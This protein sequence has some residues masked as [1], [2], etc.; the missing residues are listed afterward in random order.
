MLRSGL[1]SFNLISLLSNLAMVAEKLG[2]PAKI[3][4]IVAHEPGV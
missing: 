3:W 2:L 4:V 1:P